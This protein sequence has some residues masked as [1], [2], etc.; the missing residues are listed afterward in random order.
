M[1]VSW[2]SIK[3]MLSQRKLSAQYVIVGD[4]YWIKSIDGNFELEC[5]IPTDVT[6]SEDALDFVT[7]FLPLGNKSPQQPM[8]ISSTPAFAS[9][10]F[11][12]KGL[13]KRVVGKKF[14]LTSGVNTLL[15][16]QT[17]PWVKFMSLE[18]L[19]GEMGDTVSLYVL[20]SSTGTYTTFPNAQ[21]NQFGFNANIAPGFYQHKSEFDA[22]IYIG[23]QIKIE[24]TSISTKTIGIN[25]IMNEVK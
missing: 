13:F 21:M 20:D 12:N 25:Y 9:K 8:S 7:N 11:G 5:L 24:Y 4:N 6:I 19:N 22:D 17:M 18:I 10:T 16:T 14:E 1:Q 3:L 23:L 2:S 15:Y